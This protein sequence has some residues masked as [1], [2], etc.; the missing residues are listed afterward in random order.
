MRLF[1]SVGVK[2][3]LWYLAVFLALFH[4]C[5][6]F[7]H[8]LFTGKSKS[9]NEGECA[10]IW[11]EKPAPEEKAEAGTLEVLSTSV[12]G[13]SSDTEDDS[14]E[15]FQA[16]VTTQETKVR[17]KSLLF[18][19]KLVQLPYLHAC[20]VFTL[21]ELKHPVWENFDSGLCLKSLPTLKQNLRSK[22]PWEEKGGTAVLI[23]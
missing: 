1:Y 22:V 13:V 7:F 19:I 20:V 23:N 4:C 11:E 6:F 10:T 8:S 21:W 5:F 16:E 3:L 18:V 17:T 2:K 15:D 9:N 12:C 14:P